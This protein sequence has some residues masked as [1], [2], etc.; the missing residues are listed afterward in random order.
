MITLTDENFEKDVLNNQKPV[1]VDFY[2]VW[3]P[4]C[5]VLT[6]ILENLEK[7]Y[8]G[9]VAFAK[10]NVDDAPLL[11]KK[12]GINPIPTVMLFKGGKPISE[13]VGARPEPVIKEWL[14][15]LLKNNDK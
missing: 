15:N 9:R 2:A 1:L 10:I 7:E 4:P 5:S 11:A 3:C 8:E 12:F 6:P 14:E 13:F